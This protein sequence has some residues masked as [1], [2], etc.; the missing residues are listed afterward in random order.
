VTFIG[1]I[2]VTPEELSKLDCSQSAKL[3][4]MLFLTGATTERNKPDPRYRNETRDVLGEALA[5]MRNQAQS[6]YLKDE[7]LSTEPKLPPYGNYSEMRARWF[8]DRRTA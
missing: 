3:A 7:P 2:E 6:Y 5:D 4:Q 8:T 1:R